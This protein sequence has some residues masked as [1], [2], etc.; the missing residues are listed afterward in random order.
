MALDGPLG[1][2]SGSHCSLEGLRYYHC[3]LA[4]V[5]H[6]KSE[7]AQLKIKRAKLT[8]IVSM[9]QNTIQSDVGFI[10]ERQELEIIT[11]SRKLMNGI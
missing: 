3:I 8:V 11:G 4:R 1:P 10:V 5:L 2:G 7:L 6:P 9:T